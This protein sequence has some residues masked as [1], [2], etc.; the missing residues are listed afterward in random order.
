ML[1]HTSPKGAT[2][3]LIA[4]GMGLGA[5]VRAYISRST[6]G[7]DLL[8]QERYN[9]FPAS[10]LCGIS[11]FT[12]GVADMLPADG[13]G[14]WLQRLPP[15]SFFGPHTR[16][17]VSYN[18][19]PAQGFM[20]LMLPDALHAMTGVDVAAQVNR[21]SPLHQVLDA[22][23]CEMAQAALQAPD[24]AE[25]VRVIEA[26]LLPRWQQARTQG[27]V[28]VRSFQD[29]AETLAVRALASG[30]GQSLRQAERRVKAWTGQSLRA[31]QG[32]SRAE[33][34]FFQVRQA[35]DAG[36]VVWADLAAGA[37][38]ADQSHLCRETR[39]VTGLSPEALRQRVQDD[40]SFWVYRI[41]S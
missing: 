12:H 15:I 29:W 39:R 17:T 30:A 11:W 3:H 18:P 2:A 24:D 40:E 25:R 1:S 20:L 41:W 31:L 21:Q 10:P 16:P 8:P 35:E 37:G 13:S 33:A 32:R 9:H 28:P 38:Y 34:A 6:L 4:P 22:S 36:N 19:G 14:D 26:F 7:V 23:W 5:C 27:A